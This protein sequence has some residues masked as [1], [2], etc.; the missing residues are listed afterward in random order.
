MLRCPED[1]LPADAPEDLRRFVG[2]W[3]AKAAG[4]TM[5]AFADIDAIDI[6]WAL[7]RIYVVRALDGGADFVYRLAGE[8][9][10]L[11][12]AGSLAGR[13][14]SDLL[15]PDSARVVV[16]RWRQV[17][18]TTSAYYVDSEHP[19]SIGSRLRGRRVV[20]PLGP[21]GGPPD[22]VVGMTVFE[23]LNTGGT[24]AISGMEVQDMRWVELA[25]GPGVPAPVAP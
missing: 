16:E 18:E 2:Y 17:I 12:Y 14:I 19:T 7:S 20:L 23:A 11:R 15:A 22:H 1:L 6:P 21:D 9:I 24:G 4:R 3:I 10:N 25:G 13:R 8:A 5:P